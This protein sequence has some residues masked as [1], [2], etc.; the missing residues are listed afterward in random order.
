MEFVGEEK[1]FRF[2]VVVLNDKVVNFNCI[3]RN[4]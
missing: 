3:E 4:F 2:V 1:F